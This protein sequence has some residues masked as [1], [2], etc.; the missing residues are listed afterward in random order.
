MRAPF[1]SRALVL[2]A[3]LAL[4]ATACGG[5]AKAPPST[6]ARFN[7]SLCP[8]APRV[9]TSRPLDPALDGIS[10][11]VSLMSRTVTSTRGVH[12]AITFKSSA[13]HR[14]T[15]SLPQAAFSLA[16][17]TLVDAACRPVPYAVSPA[18]RGLAY[19]N[20]GPMPLLSGESAT[21][22]SSLD[23]LAPGLVLKPG[24]YAIRLALKMDSSSAVVRGETLLSD[25]A[26]FAV[27]PSK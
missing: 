1:S 10:A 25:W 21:I 19:G 12:L 22:D 8:A 20:S 4:L 2:G 13:L 18:A 9:D 24:I 6:M 11:S 27:L 17:F 3:A 23:D 5:G 16:G 15:L 26:L 7:A 14:V